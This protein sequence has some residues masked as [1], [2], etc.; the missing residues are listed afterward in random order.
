MR[1][2]EAEKLIGI[3]RVDKEEAPELDEDA[4]LSTPEIVPPSNAADAAPGSEPTS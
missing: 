4:P 3:V 1:M 2:V